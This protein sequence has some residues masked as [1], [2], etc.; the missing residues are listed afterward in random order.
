MRYPVTILL[1]LIASRLWG[2]DWPEFRAGPARD[3]IWNEPDLPAALPAGGPKVIWKHTVGTGFSG[4]SVAGGRVYLLDRLQPPLAAEDTERILC[5]DAA[6]GKELWIRAY[7]CALKF[8]GGY[9]NGPRA[10]PT[11]HEGKVYAL[12]SMGH[13]HCLDAESGRV[14]WQRNLLTE[15]EARIP[16][17]GMASSPL[18]E[19]QMLVL[20]A[21]GR[22]NATVVAFNK[23]TGEELWHSLSDKAGYAS[24]IAIDSAGQRQLIVWTADALCA[25][26]PR[27]GAVF[28]RHPRALRWD[29]AIAPPLFH[30]GLN[31]LFISSDREGTLALQLDR[32]RPGYKVAWDNFSLS[33]LHSL[34]VLVGD[35]LYGVNHN[36]A[37]KP[38]C[39]EFRCVE[40]ATGKIL[41]AATNLTRLGMWAQASVTFNQGNSTFY[42]LNELGELVLAKATP[43]AYR[44]LGRA[45]LIGKTW[46]HPAYA[47]R[48]IYARNETTLLCARLD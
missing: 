48:R 2:V 24:L 6:T 44:E 16:D 36:G 46:S 23:E 27:T 47:D 41:W 7:P 5:L 18:I 30:R 26:D 1:A 29:Q 31:L 38:Q 42:F 17:W 28:W 43:G 45:Q 32:A 3:A 4:P 15:Y 34:P 19:A 25:L 9:E 37:F 12:G 10:T 21:A 33:S 8:K 40:A 35:C 20:Q 22:S 11:V 39:G 14:I 13:L